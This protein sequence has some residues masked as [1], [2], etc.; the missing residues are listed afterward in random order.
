MSQKDF[1]I[2]RSLYEKANV[3]HSQFKA[4]P[5]INEALVREISTQKK[6]PV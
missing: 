6:E 2:D 5:G 4:A 1:T 3:D